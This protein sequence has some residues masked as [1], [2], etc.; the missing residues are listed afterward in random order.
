LTA[1]AEP[2][3]NRRVVLMQCQLSYTRKH[4]YFIASYCVH[5]HVLH[6]A[7]LS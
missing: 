1:M 5:N 7:D 2:E 6:P 4:I 3:G